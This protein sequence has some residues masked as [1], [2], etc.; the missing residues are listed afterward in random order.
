MRCPPII[1]LAVLFVGCAASNSG[2]ADKPI[3]PEPDPV[4]IE[5]PG[6]EKCKPACT[7][8]TE[9]KCSQAEPTQLKD[10]GVMSCEE[11]CVYQ[12]INGITW[13]N[14]CL[15]T[16]KICADIETVCGS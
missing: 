16:I 13:N 15:L 10:G 9:L 7:K 3:G 6:K 1:F 12:H 5:V 4:V 11:L 8:M 14:D 2:G